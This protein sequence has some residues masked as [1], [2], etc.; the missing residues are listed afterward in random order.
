MSRSRWLFVDF[1]RFSAVVLMVQGHT[2][3]AVLSAVERAAPWYQVHSFWHGFTA[4]MFLFASGIAFGIATLRKWEKHTAWS[5]AITRRLRR[6]GML[7]LIGY[8]LHLPFF[9][10][11][12]LMNEASYKH[13]QSFLESDALQLIG[14]CLLICQGLVFL[15]KKPNRLAWVLSGLLAG[16]VLV[17]PLLW[18]IPF[19]DTLPLAV[20]SY[21]NGQTGSTFPIFPWS[22]YLFAGV[23]TAIWLQ[24]ATSRAVSTARLGQ[25]AL[26]GVFLLVTSL[27]LTL[28][29][30]TGAVYGFDVGWRPNPLVFAMRLGTILSFL[31]VLYAIERVI[32]YR[33]KRSA[34]SE[35]RAVA[36]VQLMASET[37]SIYVAH[38]MVLYG[39]VLN[40]G[41]ISSVGRTLPIWASIL[42][43][44]ILFAGMYGFAWAW[45]YVK[46]D[47]I[48]WLRFAQV[49]SVLLFGYFFFTNPF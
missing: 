35:G 2:F 30:A 48:A 6:Y 49:A 20:A 9:S 7:I 8:F 11:T 13:W 40:L 10:Y 47:R 29:D 45:S 36:A 38:L 37:L 26:V 32:V 24:P 1:L 17:C 44:L 12:K 5:T 22:G 41:L 31:G 16:V 27:G 46:R 3:D 43:F 28:I 15:L 42:I 25:V 33:Q 19:D 4:P 34:P 39:S 23:L 18:T 21:L 14:W